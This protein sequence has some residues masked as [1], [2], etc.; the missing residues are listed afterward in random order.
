MG[1]TWLAK[2]CI[3][4]ICLK[5]VTLQSCQHEE[6]VCHAKWNFNIF[7]TTFRFH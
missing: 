5:N 3:K 6:V 1:K 2:K 4:K 7:L